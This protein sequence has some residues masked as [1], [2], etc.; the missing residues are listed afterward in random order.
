M[1]KQ[2]EVKVEL[3]AVDRASRV[4]RQVGQNADKLR[5]KFDSMSSA[6][7]G[8]LSGVGAGALGGAVGGGVAFSAAI[9]NAS[10]FEYALYQTTK[11]TSEST[12]EIRRKILELP[13][14]LG[15]A[16]ELT[17]GYYQV[18]SAGVTDSA[19]ALDLL[20]TA[21]KLAAV[22]EVSQ[23]EAIQALTKMMAGYRGE[24]QSSADAADMLLDI[25]KLGQASVREL[26]PVIGDL[27]SA[28]QTAGVSTREMVAALALLTQT[29][30]SPSQAATQFRA[31]EMALLS[32]SDNM[33]KI[34]SSLGAKNARELVSQHGLAGALSLIQQAAEKSGVAL[35]SVYGSQEAF[36]A[37]SGLAANGFRTYAETLSHVGETADATARSF[38]H[39]Q[40]T[41][42]GVEREGTA[43]FTNLLTLVGQEFL[44]S[45]KEW[46]G[47]F[48]AYMREN[49]SE[50][51]SWGRSAAET[52]Q[53][54]GAN[55]GGMIDL[56]KSLPD[57]ITG[58]AGYGVVGAMLFGRTGAVV[59][60]AASLIGPIQN[61]G[62]AITAMNNGDLSFWDFATS[63]AEELEERLKKIDEKRKKAAEQPAS[64]ALSLS[65]RKTTPSAPQSAPRPASDGTPEFEVLLPEGYKPFSSGGSASAV[66][67]ALSRVAEFR[68][69]ISEM[70]GDSASATLE[71]EKTLLSISETGA[72]AQ[73]SAQEIAG[74]KR[75]YSEAWSG[76]QLEEFN[77]KLL[78]AQGSTRALKEL[79]VT[80]TVS[81]WTD[82]LQ[83]A[84]LSLD[85]AA[86]KA[87]QLGEA[88]RTSVDT[89]SLE[90]VNSVL[91]E[92][93][94]KTGQYG[95][96][97]ETSNRLLETQVQLWKQAGVPEEFIEQLREIRE[98]E[99]STGAW[100]GISRATSQYYAEATNLG[101][102][103]ETFTT[104][105]FS[106]FEDAFTQFVTTGKLSFTDLANSIIA[107][108]VRISVQAMV[109]APIAKGLSGFF[110]GFFG[111]MSGGFFGGASGGAPVSN[112]IE[113][114]LFSARGNVFSGGD[115][116]DFSG[117]VITQPQAFSYGTRLAPFARGAGLMGE[118]GPE[119]VMPLVRASGG[120]LGVRSVGGAAPNVTVNLIN[121]SKNDLEASASAQSDGKGGWNIEI[122]LDQI[123][124]GLVK[125]DAAGRS[126]LMNHVDRTRGISRAGGLYR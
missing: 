44:P 5:G 24:I 80:E 20:Q 62:R 120:Y 114:P 29:S 51:S 23:G 82:R 99:N 56:W 113:T 122:M 77:K 64:A 26:I 74:L 10:D 3:S 25:E 33:K 95:L 65:T 87:Q 1:A 85:E 106:S 38:E 76:Q 92:L 71:L 12:D 101:K 102:Q 59:G 13:A 104:G 72:K 98:L 103:F 57:E 14:S 7:G 58:A 45:V 126:A 107:D 89:Q 108:L 41:F 100:A 15:S 69:E 115:L 83:A 6:A 91:K 97:L 112:V 11:V 105:M 2:A 118:A 123:E 67:A 48:N 43:A 75:E 37:A 61:I 47:A 18:L 34:V 32:S 125:R 79:E 35:A 54:L 28:S 39:F 68:R 94:E 49:S 84:G 9:K 88:L 22:A 55:V 16:T 110:S 52:L 90:T 31:L 124:S 119:A 111:G 66:Q 36:M 46:L 8:M 27:A 60:L 63:N 93:E 121:N 78:Q 40:G 116:S 73:L 53:D 117:R 86:Q 70:R 17:Q 30:G 81:E 4:F 50:I 21:S 96:S 109:V 19:E 42:R